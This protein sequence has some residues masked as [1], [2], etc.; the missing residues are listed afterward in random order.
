M[1]Q[2]VLPRHMHNQRIREQPRSEGTLRC[3][4]I[5]DPAQ[6]RS[7]VQGRTGLDQTQA[8]KGWL[9]LPFPT[10]TH[11]FHACA[12]QCCGCCPDLQSHVTTGQH[13]PG[14]GDAFIP[15]LATDTLS[16]H[17]VQHSILSHAGIEGA[18]EVIT[19]SLM[20]HFEAGLT[21]SQFN[22]IHDC[23]YEGSSESD[24]KSRS[25]Q[26][27]KPDINTSLKRK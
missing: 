12:V 24:G 16:G 21:R 22:V 11:A 8:I 6:G 25:T 26:R 14:C 23:F 13:K 10:D 15:G 9:L 18:L 4:L 2:P 19:E 3:C 5:Q 1:L 17:S 20:D 7:S 27:N